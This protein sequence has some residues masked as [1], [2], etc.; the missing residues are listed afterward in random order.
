M[1]TYNNIDKPFWIAHSD[2][3]KIVH[4]GELQEASEV[5]TA[6]PNFL[7]YAKKSKWVDKLKNLGIEITK[8]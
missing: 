1:K 6:Q 8:I 5:A 7:S 4:Y 3:F 2:N